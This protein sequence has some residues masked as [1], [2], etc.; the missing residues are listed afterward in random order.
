MLEQGSTPDL[1]DLLGSI[2]IAMIMLGL[3][4]VC[5]RIGVP[6]VKRVLKGLDS[7]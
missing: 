6:L 2:Y 5:E 4:V 1:S 7:E 3:R